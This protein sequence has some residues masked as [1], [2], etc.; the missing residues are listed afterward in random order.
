MAVP[1]QVTEA[2]P[3]PVLIAPGGFI[4]KTHEHG[5]LG[6]NYVYKTQAAPGKLNEIPQLD[7]PLAPPGIHLGSY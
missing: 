5:M 3:S 1:G 7:G 6:S 2:C 4:D